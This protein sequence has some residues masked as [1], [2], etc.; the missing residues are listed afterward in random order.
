MAEH[1]NI[2]IFNISLIEFC[3]ECGLCCTK[4][5]L[6][7]ILGTIMHDDKASKGYSFHIY[8]KSGTMVRLSPA[9][10]QAFIQLLLLL[11]LLL[12]LLLLFLNLLLLFILLLLPPLLSPRQ[13]AYSQP[14]DQVIQI[15]TEGF[16]A[17]PG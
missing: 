10:V 1:V 14:G 17:L 16:P 7:F 13:G 2:G 11:D 15:V 9:P 4:L 3:F 6:R 8:D 12:L 5:W